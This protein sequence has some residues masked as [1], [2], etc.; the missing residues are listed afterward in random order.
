MSEQPVHARKHDRPRLL[1]RPSRQPPPGPP[2]P[3]YRTAADP[4]EREV[5]AGLDRAGM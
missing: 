2:S 1:T 3:P 4:G 5:L